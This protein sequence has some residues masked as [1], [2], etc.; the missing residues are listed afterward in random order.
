MRYIKLR[1]LVPLFALLISICPPLSSVGAEGS[2]NKSDISS[3]LV[4]DQYCY[5]YSFVDRDNLT[6]TILDNENHDV[7]DLDDYILYDTKHNL[8]E[9]VNKK[10][11]VALNKTVVTNPL[12]SI[13]R[14]SEDGTLIPNSNVQ[15]IYDNE[16]AY[17]RQLQSRDTIIYGGLVPFV[18]VPDSSLAT[19]DHF[20]NKDSVSVFLYFKRKF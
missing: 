1:F 9:P 4:Q 8:C 3:E 19:E 7:N 12:S 14:S 5:N 11:V 17:L 16:R 18:A 13:P 10:L 15:F 2:P 20:F 6:G